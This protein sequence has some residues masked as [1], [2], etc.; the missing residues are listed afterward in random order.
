MSQLTLICSVGS[1]DSALAAAWAGFR[2]IASSKKTPTAKRCSRNIGRRSRL[3]RLFKFGGRISDQACLQPD[4]LA[5][6]TVKPGSEEARKMTAQSGQR[7]FEL[8]RSDK[9]PLGAW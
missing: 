2:T 9:A 4:F 7:Y 8:Y 3:P 6:H 5:S 1:E